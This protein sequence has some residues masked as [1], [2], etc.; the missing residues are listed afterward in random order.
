MAA[1]YQFAPVPLVPMIEL[2][3]NKHITNTITSF[4]NSSSNYRFPL[5]FIAK[6]PKANV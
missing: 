4:I 6:L 3:I 2:A 5:E 1:Y